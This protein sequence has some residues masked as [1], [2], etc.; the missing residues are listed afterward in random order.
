MRSIKAVHFSV[1]GFG[2][3]GSE[4]VGLIKYMIFATAKKAYKMWEFFHEKMK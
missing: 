3:I 2:T 4:K 1:L